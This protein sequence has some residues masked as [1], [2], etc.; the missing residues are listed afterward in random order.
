M[1]DNLI[2]IID[3]F[4]D[5]AGNHLQINSFGFGNVAEIMTSGTVKHPLLYCQADGLVAQSGE[6]G[7]KFKV[8][9]MDI[10]D[11]D[12]TNEDNVLNDTVQILLDFFAEFFNAGKGFG[13]DN[14]FELR[15]DSINAT[16]FLE[17]RFQDETAGWEANITI[18]SKFNWNRCQ[19]PKQ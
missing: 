2:N 11:K 19:I 16:T 8:L 14:N 6:V 3:S 18:W 1:S 12:K 13:Q 15:Q 9:I 5:F 7:Y 4:G 10:V 17:D